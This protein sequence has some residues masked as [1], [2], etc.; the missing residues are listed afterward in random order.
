MCD[1]KEHNNENY[2]C[3]CSKVPCKCSKVPCK[4]KVQ[5]SCGQKCDSCEHKKICLVPSV[6]EIFRY[7]TLIFINKEWYETYRIPL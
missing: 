7:K 5:L 2:I 1:C 6:K 3:K 4:Y